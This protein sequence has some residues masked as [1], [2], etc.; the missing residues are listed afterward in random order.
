[1]S[2]GEMTNSE[3]HIDQS[4]AERF[5]NALPKDHSFTFHHVST[6]PTRSP[7]LYAAPPGHKP[8]RTYT[9]SHFLAVSIARPGDGAQILVLAIEVLIYTTRHLTTIFVSKADST[10]YLGLLGLGKGHASPLRTVAT[11]FLTFLVEKRRRDGVKVVLSLFARANDQ[12]L[13]PGSVENKGKHV[14]DDRQL[15]KWWCRVLDPV[16]QKYPGVVEDSTTTTKDGIT[17]QA[18]L[19]VPGEDSI[20]P[21]LPPAVRLSP[22]L[23]QR[24]KHGHPLYSITRY[25]TAPPRCLVPHF[26]DDPKA[27]FL[28]ELDDE[29][30]DNTTSSQS[31]SHNQKSV[32]DSPSKRGN[33]IWKSVR[34][35]EQF[36]EMMAFR[37]E[38][39]SGRLVGFIWI[40]FSPSTE[41]APQDTAMAESQESADSVLSAPSSPSRKTLQPP[42]PAR[43]VKSNPITKKRPKPLRGPIHPR[44][45]KIKRQSSLPT[46]FS[47]SSKPLPPTTSPYYHWP[48]SSRG[49]LIL[50]AKDYSKAVDRL[51]KLQFRDEKTAIVSSRVWVEEVGVLAGRKSWGWSVVGLEAAEV[52][53]VP[54]RKEDGGLGVSGMMVVKKK[55]KAADEAPVVETQGEA[56]NTLGAG[57]VKKK[58]K[59]APV[60]MS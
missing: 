27:R 40:V 33:G 46:S 37:Q 35:L 9:E 19:I 54:Q 15:V 20:T 4:L 22:A 38:C 53:V 32:Q 17:A 28:D 50:P 48:A 36:W 30:P 29:L 45:P 58:K 3:P 34:S 2:I 6:P 59:I 21:Y 44:T 31:Q 60:S 7:A 47:S 52:N 8:S 10:G 51:L 57:L 16:L 5:A 41:A 56:V 1:M 39:S 26:P 42:T 25:P 11:V 49:E 12:Y 14:S 18:Y 13:F 55:R 43:R 23:R 24:W